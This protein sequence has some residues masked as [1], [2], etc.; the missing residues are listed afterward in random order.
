[1]A[2]TLNGPIK[3]RS[4]LYTRNKG[5]HRFLGWAITV[6]TLGSMVEPFLV[7]DRTIPGMSVPNHDPSDPMARIDEL[8][9]VPSG[10]ERQLMSDDGLPLHG[11]DLSPRT[12]IRTG[13]FDGLPDS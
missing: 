11:G 6:T 10:M 9:N 3:R 7:N 13:N 12:F 5:I 8:Q 2:K 1:M 4:V